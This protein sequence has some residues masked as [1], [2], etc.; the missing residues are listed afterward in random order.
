[1]LNSFKSPQIVGLVGAGSEIGTQIVTHLNQNNLQKILLA[2]REGNIKY[3]DIGIPIKCD[4]NNSQSRK[5]L[6]E[7]LF[8]HGDLDLAVIAIGILKGTLDEI[9]Q[10]NYVA[11]VDLLSQIANRM[12]T[13]GHGKIVV[14]SSFAQTRPRLDNYAYGS[15]KAGLDFFARGLS[16]E[17]RGTGV[18]VLILRP[19][20]VHTKMTSGMDVAPFAI[21]PEQTGAIAAV[22]INGTASISYAPRV[23]RILAFIFRLIPKF[24]FRRLI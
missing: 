22:A 3:K 6:V 13:Q 14:I 12:K 9:M 16:E 2:S 18:S 19:G 24:V 20:F 7:E 10:V 11:S 23:L 21:S 5:T 1:M 17:L 8:S 4:F 15:T